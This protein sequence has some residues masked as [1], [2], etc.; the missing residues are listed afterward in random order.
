MTFKEEIRRIHSD[1]DSL[2]KQFPRTLSSSIA[3][4]GFLGSLGL[5]AFAPPGLILWVSSL[6]WASVSQAQL[7]HLASKLI[8]AQQIREE[9][10]QYQFL[11]VIKVI[12]QWEN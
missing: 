4:V 2:S 1:Y 11:E 5:S 12:Q 7:V 6:I 3:L 9:I 10:K 8:K